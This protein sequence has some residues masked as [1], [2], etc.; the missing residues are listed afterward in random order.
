MNKFAKMFNKSFPFITYFLIIIYKIQI[1]ECAPAIKNSS[2]ME[3]RGKGD[4]CINPQTQKMVNY[5]KLNGFINSDLIEKVICSIDRKLFMNE[6]HLVIEAEAY[7]DFNHYLGHG[8]SFSA[9][10][11]HAYALEIF[12]DKLKFKNKKDK[13][14]ILDVGS[15]SGYL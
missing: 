14:K 3:S 5:L 11:M 7:L 2:N 8:A 1:C 12:Y 15:G 10:S 4:K 13:I 6:R 9:P